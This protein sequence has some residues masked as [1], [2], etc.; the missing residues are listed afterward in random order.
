[1][2]IGVWLAK[3]SQ[4]GLWVPAAETTA[5]YLALSID[6]L[7]T[8]ATGLAFLAALSNLF[9]V[10]GV[11]LF[12]GVSGPQREGCIGNYEGYWIVAATF[13]WT[14]CVEGFVMYV[15]WRRGRN[16]QVELEYLLN[17]QSLLRAAAARRKTKTFD[18]LPKPICARTILH[19]R[20]AAGIA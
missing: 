13:L 8:N 19:G 12:R 10:T 4:K 20:P 11:R 18:R 6:T 14:I 5:A 7:Q 9:V 15:L 1:M 3:R 17:L 2:A 16:M